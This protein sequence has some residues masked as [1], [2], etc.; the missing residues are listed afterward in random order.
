[1]SSIPLRIG[2]T[3]GIAS[4]KSAVA[5]EFAALGVPVIDADVIARELVEPG[6]PALSRIVEAFGPQVLNASGTLDRRQMR[7][8]VF[9]SPDDRR[10]LE[11]ILHPAVRTELDR[12]SQTTSGPYVILVIPLLVENDLQS[13][14]DRILVVDVPEET[15]LRRLC[16]RDGMDSQQAQKMMAAQAT[17]A[18]RLAVAHDVIENVGT[19]VELRN[20]VRQMHEKYRRV[21]ERE[22][23]L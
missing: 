19:L 12:R 1:M 13:L 22:K 14:V 7:E 10:R 23:K 20:G 2:L 16:T 15:Q 11:A 8:R 9:A 21:A 17:R 5:D 3:G 6:Q 18:A 4:G